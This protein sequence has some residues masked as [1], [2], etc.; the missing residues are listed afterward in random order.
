MTRCWVTWPAEVRI[1]PEIRDVRP[2]LDQ[3]VEV[4]RQHRDIDD[5]NFDYLEGAGT[6]N[7]VLLVRHGITEVIAKRQA[8]HALHAMLPSAGFDT[9]RSRP[10]SHPEI[11]WLRF[12]W[13]PTSF[14][15]W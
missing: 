12:D 13:W 6:V 7:F 1:R 10:A 11:A 14:T 8:S 3:G 9:G 4:L 15:W 5:A 2:Y